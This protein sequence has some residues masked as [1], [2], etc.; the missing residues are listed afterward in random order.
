M[1]CHKIIKYNFHVYRRDKEKKIALFIIFLFIVVLLSSILFICYSINTGCFGRYK[2]NK[3]NKMK[4]FLFSSR[5][6]SESNIKM[7]SPKKQKEKSEI[8]CLF[9]IKEMNYLI[10]FL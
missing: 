8:W 5:L 10:W 6:E 1:T 4:K 2:N 3:S 9:I 7:Y